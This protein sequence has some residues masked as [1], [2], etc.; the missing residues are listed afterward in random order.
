MKQGAGRRSDR[1]AGDTILRASHRCGR[2]PLLDPAACIVVLLAPSQRDR[3]TQS[4][5]AY[6]SYQRKTATLTSAARIAAIPTFFCCQAAEPEAA[7]DPDRTFTYEAQGFIW[8]NEAFLRALDAED[9][10]ALVLAGYWFDCHVAAAALYALADCY[11]VYIP[12]DASPGRSREAMR[13]AETRL[14]QAGATALLT[15]QVIYEWAIEISD[16]KRQAELT[17]LIDD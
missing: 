11:D 10:S 12:L 13:L 4:K 6:G 5:R 9:R 17:A 16:A 2:T 8:K 1:L 14:F 15:E 3:L 7:G